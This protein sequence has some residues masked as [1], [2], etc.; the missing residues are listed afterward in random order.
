MISADTGTVSI[1][2]T[3]VSEAV[4]QVLRAS[5]RPLAAAQI[6]KR[7]TGPELTET[8]LKQLLEQLAQ[9][10]RIHECSPS[11]S[12]R[13]FWIQDERQLTREKIL[14]LVRQQPRTRRKVLAE[15]RASLNTGASPAYREQI[16]DELLAERQ[17][18]NHPPGRGGRNPLLSTEPLK[19]EQF[20]PPRLVG[21]L[22]RV[23]DKL[24]D[25]GISTQQV[26]TVLAEAVEKSLREG[27]AKSPAPEDQS[28]AADAAGL[29]LSGP[30]PQPAGNLPTTGTSTEEIEQLI[31]KGMYDVEPNAPTGAR[32]SLRELRERMPAAYQQPEVFDRAV[33]RLAERGRVSLHRLDDTQPLSEEERNRLVRDDQGQLYEYIVQRPQ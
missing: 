19:L 11:G 26:L 15:L 2:T 7:Y 28:P 32:V 24:Q 20:L 29:P 8:R 23:C 3:E 33:F 25:L 22:T 16:I 17:L 18:F 30:G 4:L 13:R 12:A 9:E 27:R 21:E 1:Q 6:R 14:D 10:G 31:L 5:D